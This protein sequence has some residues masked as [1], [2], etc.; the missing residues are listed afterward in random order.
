M[1]TSCLALAAAILLAN[2]QAHARDQT[3]A[4][5]GLPATSAQDIA[6]PQQAQQPAPAAQQTAAAPPAEAPDADEDDLVVT[7]RRASP[8]DPLEKINVETYKT[9]QVVDKAVVAPAAESYKK[10][11]PRPVRD[12]VRNFFN[13][14][15]EPVVFLNY[16]LQI[17]PGKAFET[18]GRFGLNSTVGVAGFFDIAKRRPFKL[19]LRRNGFANTMG[20]Y[21]VG[22]GPFLFLPL[23]GPTTVR[24]IIG[25]GFDKALLP[26][27]VGSPFG[28]PLFSIPSSAVTSL[29]YRVEFDTQLR[30][31]A[32]APDPYA[33]SRE[34]YLRS[35]QAEI[36]ALHGRAPSV[37]ATGA[38]AASTATG[39]LIA[40]SLPPADNTSESV[41]TA[42]TGVGETPVTPTPA[43]PITDGASVPAN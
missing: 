2:A 13:N 10:A 23:V 20:Y 21:G 38:P 25:L 8:G 36:D 9:V 16:L 42:P 28:N 18:A 24:D 31:Q 15:T 40:P 22:P 5:S 41:T 29:D 7:G 1:R 11:L 39:P 35:R 32:E 34:N 27:T 17:K 14:L 33:A 26:F 37:P 4:G 43:A 6:P 19:P 12:G 30:E 3:P